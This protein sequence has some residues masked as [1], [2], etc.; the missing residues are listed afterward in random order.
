MKGW[1][2]HHRQAAAQ[3]FRRLSATPLNTLLGA[4]VLGIALGLP[5]GGEM[6]L[7]NFLRLAQ[8]VAATP[9]I[10]VFM[11]LDAAK[12]EIAE[13]ESLLRKHPQTRE[14]RL[15]QRED[16][17]KRFKE[18]EGLAEV[19]ESLP[20]NPF[21]DAF[22]VVPRDESSAALEA[23]RAEFAKYPRVEHV[24]LDSA[25]V[26]KLD[27]L[28]R[29]ARLAVTLLAAV[30]GIALVAVTFNTIRLQI[31]TQQEEIEVSRLLGA[32]D[33]FIRRPFYYFGALQ[34]LAGGLVAWSAVL[35]ATLLLRGPVADLAALYGIEFALHILPLADSVLLF[36]LAALLGWAG[37]WLSLTRHLR[38]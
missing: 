28:L 8:R 21:P 4:L 14:V 1:L 5:A 13:I 6:L 3:A 23:M 26:K 32:T 18:S 12:K 20:R 30:L 9:Q 17:L 36:G 34:G 11:A 38:N 35:I 25:W 10:S 2:L 7:A 22:V 33:A 29:L 31:L 19:I 16:T 37:A 15:V 24:Q 27:A